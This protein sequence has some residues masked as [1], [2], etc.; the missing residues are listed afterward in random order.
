MLEDTIDR[1][2]PQLVRL[3]L[4][5]KP[6]RLA[7]VASRF[8]AHDVNILRVEVVAAGDGAAVDDLLVVGGNL[9]LALE[10]LRA[11]VEI[12]GRT[13]ACGAA[14]SRDRDGGCARRR[15]RFGQSRCGTARAADRGARAR[16]GRWRR[17]LA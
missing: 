6:G 15:Q 16:R 1:E 4:P 3:A 11:D 8:A 2:E 13:R 14:R 9:A 5:D 12:L 7:L 17:A 10:E